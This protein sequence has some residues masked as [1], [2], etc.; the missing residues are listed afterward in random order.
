M[1]AVF[2]AVP[3]SPE[4][5]ALINVILAGIETVIGV[6]TANSPA[7]VPAPAAATPEVITSGQAIHAHAVAASTE[8]KVT[9]LTGFKPSFWDKARAAAGDTHVAAGH[10]NSEWNKAVD[11]GGFPATLKV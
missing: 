11:A 3:I 8:A 7:P 5:Q 1:N 9:A 4:L 10:Y 6:V 2:T